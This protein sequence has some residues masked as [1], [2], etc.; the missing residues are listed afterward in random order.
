MTTSPQES[1]SGLDD[2]SQVDG[3]SSRSAPDSQGTD[4]GGQ[5]GTTESGVE[6]S[7][8]G[9]GAQDD[10]DPDRQGKNPL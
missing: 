4:V 1:G 2:T 5:A 6:E 3:R 7:V 8:T 10:E 9:S